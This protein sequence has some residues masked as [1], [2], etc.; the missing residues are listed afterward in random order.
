MKALITG[1]AGFTGKRLI[2]ELLARGDKVKVLD[3]N[4]AN[5]AEMKSPSVELI[6]GGIEDREKVKLAVKDADVIY[7]LAETF[8]SDPYEVVDVDI[9]GLVN[10]LESAVENK[11][12]HFLFA[13]THR[14]YGTPRYA[15]MDEEHPLHPEESRR[16]LYSLSKLTREQIGLTYWREHELPFTVLRW[17]YSIDPTQPMQGK[18]LK[19][20]I[21]NALKGEVIRLPDKGGGDFILNE[22][23]VRG[24]LTA[25]LNEK[26][27]GQVFNITSGAYITWL[28]LA[29]VVLELTASSSKLETIPADKWQGDPSITM[30]TTLPFECSLDI[31][32]AKRLLGYKPTY[33]A[34]EVR[35]MLRDS[36]GK[37]V[38]L[39]KQ[40]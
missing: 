30:D 39:R 13:S 19:A 40:G 28:D 32:K 25:T 8:S 38:E 15:P 12:K 29:R 4:L 10:L 20:M 7:H 14:V 11:V 34:Q 35:H 33:S 24:F 26:G 27:F 23:T 21:D 3:K 22:D 2:N 37:L 1:G 9:K 5:I 17:W 6:E 31:S 18:V 16:P 36:T